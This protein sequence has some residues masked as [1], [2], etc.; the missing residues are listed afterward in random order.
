MFEI[1]L[2]G[3]LGT[4]LKFIQIFLNIFC[5][6]VKGTATKMQGDGCQMTTI[7]LKSLGTP[8]QKRHLA[9]KTVKENFKAFNLNNSAFYKILDL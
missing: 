4:V 8:A 2:T 1:R 3:R 6:Q 9:P 5:V 7:T